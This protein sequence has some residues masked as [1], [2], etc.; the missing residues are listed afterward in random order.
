MTD[1]A[2]RETAVRFSRYRLAGRERDAESGNDYASPPMQSLG[3]GNLYASG[4]C[5]IL[6]FAWKEFL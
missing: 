4:P 5:L 1:S 2:V 6:A 3:I